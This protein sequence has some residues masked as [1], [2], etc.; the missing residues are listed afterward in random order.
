MTEGLKGK[1]KC[2][3]NQLHSLYRELLFHFMTECAHIWQHLSL[4]LLISPIGILGQVWYLIVSIPDLCT[5]TYFYGVQ[6]KTKVTDHYY[7]LGIKGQGQ[8]NLE[9]VLWLVTQTPLLFL[10]LMFHIVYN[11]CQYDMSQR[12]MSCI[13]ESLSLLYLLFIS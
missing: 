8:I 3:S 9:T 2:T 6:I 13:Y 12:S 7:D 10:I 1:V 4:M 11:D 5:I